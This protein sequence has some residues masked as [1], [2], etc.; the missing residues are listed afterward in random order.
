MSTLVMVRITP[1]LLIE[2]VELLFFAVGTVVLSGVGIFLEEFAL[3]TVLGGE[4]LLG[5][6]VAL[7]GLMAFYFGPYLMGYDQFLPRLAALRTKLTASDE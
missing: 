3:A 4:P 1:E 5:A 2:L 6:W 7:M